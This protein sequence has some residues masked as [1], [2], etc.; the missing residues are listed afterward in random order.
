MD[1]HLPRSQ[2]YKDMNE[3]IWSYDLKSELT[4]LT[5]L[6][7][8]LT[9]SDLG[10]LPNG[11]LCFFVKTLKITGKVHLPGRDVE[12]YAGRLIC[13]KDALIDVSGKNGMGFEIGDRAAS[14]TAPGE[15]GANGQAAISGSSSGNV[16]I[17]CGDF[18]G[19]LELRVRG[20]NGGRGQSGGNGV[21][22]Q[23]GA[24]AVDAVEPKKGSAGNVSAPQGLSG[25]N[26]GN[27]GF[28]GTSGNGGNGGRTLLQTL[29]MSPGSSCKTTDFGEG[30]A[31]TAAEHGTAGIGGKGGRGAYGWHCEWVDP[32]HFVRPPGRPP[33]WSC[34][35]V[36]PGSSGQDG[37]YGLNPSKPPQPGVPG[38]RGSAETRSIFSEDQWKAL[39]FTAY[40]QLESTTPK[41]ASQA[42]ETALAAL[43]LS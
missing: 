43:I 4:K 20:G 8:D 21:N 23:S 32:N 39:S 11:R 40:S 30:F 10:F 33:M 1:I 38:I 31:G 15:S 13:E 14:G 37:L 7:Y 26:G 5:A 36:G 24:N 18:E 16:R 6:N 17:V 42:E 29:V 2:Q 19:L 34:E 27:A 25:G 12:I 9:D 3:T 22:G 28:A 35:R 41:D